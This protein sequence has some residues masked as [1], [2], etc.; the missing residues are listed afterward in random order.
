MKSVEIIKENK[1]LRQH[2]EVLHNCWQDAQRR[3]NSSAARCMNLIADISVRDAR[4][5]ELEEKLCEVEQHLN[6]TEELAA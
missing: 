4:I 3:A 6:P 1:M 5:Q 2:N